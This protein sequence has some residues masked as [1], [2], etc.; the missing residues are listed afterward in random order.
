MLGQSEHIQELIEQSAEELFSANSA[1]K[2][3]LA[4]TEP[5]PGVKSAVDRNEGVAKKLQ[6][7]SKSLRAVH[8]ALQ[9][10]MRDRN[11]VDHQLAAAVEQEEG[12]RHAALHDQ[13]TG[14]PNRTLFKDR[15]E[16]GIA[17]AKRH[18]CFLAVMFV[19]L[20]KFKYINDTHGHQAGDFVLQTVAVRLA[21]TTRDDD[22]V[23]RYGGDEFLCL[24]T[25]LHERGDI[26]MIAA[27]IQNA[28]RAPCDVLLGEAKVTL[29]IEASIGISMF[30]QDGSSA[31]ELIARADEAMYRAK[32]SG[33]RVAFAQ[34]ESAL[35]AC[36]A[37]YR[38]PLDV[39]NSIWG[40]STNL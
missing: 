9:V 14:L 15:L 11:L 13:L 10:E 29:C 6:D 33:S 2:Q 21:Q 1:I 27:K 5:L 17:H 7:A 26:R 35:E 8:E 16:H 36:A 31:A 18:G 22:T 40:C 34:P 20:D 39:V 37:T 32:E 4:N 24:L 38:Q 25:P 28:I 19:D 12:S 23:S 3:E 30:P